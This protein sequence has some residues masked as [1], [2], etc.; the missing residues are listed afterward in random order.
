MRVFPYRVPPLDS[1]GGVCFQP[2]AE[3]RHLQ[4]HRDAL[5]VLCAFPPA[6]SALTP[7]PG[8]TRTPRALLIRLLPFLCHL[9][10]MR[11]FSYRVPPLDS[12]ACG[13][14]QPA[15]EFRHLQRH[16]D[17]LHVPCAL[18]PAPSALTPEP[19]HT[20]TPRALLIRPSLSVPS[21]RHA[22]LPLSGASFGLGRGR[23]LSTSR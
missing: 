23:L 12:A 8:H 2:A 4:R 13:C 7:E 6:P 14:F 19:G 9:Y 10:A 5:H 11:A 3:L 1:V 18:P 17:E 22:C 21:L 20:R 16:R 15:A